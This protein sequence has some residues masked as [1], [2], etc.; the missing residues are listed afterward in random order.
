MVHDFLYLVWK[1]PRERRNYIIGK[2]TRKEKY[3]FEY[4][5]D[6]KEAKKAGW[7]HLQ[8]FHDEKEYVSD[9]LFAV[10]EA[11]LPDPKRRDIDEIL[12]KYNLQEYDGFEL[13]RKSTGRLPIDTYEFIDPIFPEE[14]TVEREFFIVG[15]RHYAKCKGE[16]C[17][18]F[19]QVEVGT[20]L[21]LKREP[22]NQHDKYAVCVTTCDGAKIG[23]IPR[24]YSE[25]IFDRLKKGMTYSCYVVEKHSEKNCD[26][27]VK[28]QLKIPRE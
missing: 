15:V 8:A 22:D 7:E 27:C 2:L 24:Y 4:C 25:S 14:E 5:G 23:Y 26:C 20:E 11:R 9:T 19:N 16:D 1:D 13:L 12:R 21:N 18:S 6:Y 17:A 10:F 3:E 28:V